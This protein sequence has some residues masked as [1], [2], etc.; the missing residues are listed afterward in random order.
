MS[1]ENYF[2]RPYKDVDA[3]SDLLSDLSNSVEVSTDYVNRYEAIT[4]RWSRMIQYKSSLSSSVNMAMEDVQMMLNRLEAYIESKFRNIIRAYYVLCSTSG[5][6]PRT[7]SDLR[8]LVDRNSVS[9]LGSVKFDYDTMKKWLEAMEGFDADGDGYGDNYI[10]RVRVAKMSYLRNTHGLKIKLNMLLTS[11]KPDFKPLGQ[12]STRAIKNNDMLFIR[13]KSVAGALGWNSF[14]D[15]ILEGVELATTKDKGLH[16]SRNTISGPVFN[17]YPADGN[18]LM[19]P[20]RAYLFKGKFWYETINKQYSL[21]AV[22]WSAPQA[23]SLFL[24]QGGTAVAYNT[25]LPEVQV[26]SPTGVVLT[27]ALVERSFVRISYRTIEDPDG[28]VYIG[29][30]FEFNVIVTVPDNVDEG[31]LR[32]QCSQIGAGESCWV[33]LE[34][35]DSYHIGQ[36]TGYLTNSSVVTSGSMESLITTLSISEYPSLFKQME[37][38]PEFC[39]LLISYDHWIR[40]S[41]NANFIVAGIAPKYINTTLVSMLNRAFPNAIQFSDQ[42][43]NPNAVLLSDILSL[44]LFWDKKYVGVTTLTGD[45]KTTLYGILYRWIAWV[46]G[47]MLNDPGFINDYYGKNN[48]YYLE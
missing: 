26:I 31:T 1:I 24:A 32:M 21:A 19:R 17:S 13:N 18:I 25:L 11:L 14:D 34:S 28:N 40:S 29:S 30:Y 47:V 43:G 15:G 22:D 12:Y 5:N 38:W 48:F 3:L 37:G 36:I 7:L 39:A 27:T 6:L 45:Q 4:R 16:V 8:M 42:A 23:A 44:S 10:S 33:E 35:I 46:C 20:G 2:Q 9:N 41:P